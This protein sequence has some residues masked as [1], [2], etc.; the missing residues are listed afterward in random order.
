MR[1]Q[2]LDNQLFGGAVGFGY[3]VKLALELEGNAALKVVRQQRTGLAR[4]FDG[5]FQVGQ[6]LTLFL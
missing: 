1:A 4:N 3:Q 2:A 6:A 5:R